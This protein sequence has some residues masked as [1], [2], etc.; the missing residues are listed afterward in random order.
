VR[1]QNGAANKARLLSE[2]GSSSSIVTEG[3]EC[4][5]TKGKDMQWPWV[6]FTRE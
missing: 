4:T 6:L 1:W 3:K 2:E 5:V